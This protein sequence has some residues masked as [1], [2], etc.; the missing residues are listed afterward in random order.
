MLVELEATLKVNHIDIIANTEV[1]AQNSEILKITSFQEFIKL[2]LVDR[3]LGKKGGGV[4]VFT[5]NS[6][7]VEKLYYIFTAL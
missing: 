5:K 3:P 4:M 7:K 1:Q 6:I 2:Y